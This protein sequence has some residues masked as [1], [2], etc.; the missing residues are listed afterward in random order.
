[1]GE[2]CKEIPAVKRR[3]YVALTRQ[4]TTGQ[5]SHW[6]FFSFFIIIT[7]NHRGAR[8]LKRHT[9]HLLISI[10]IFLVRLVCR[11]FGFVL[12]TSG[13]S[14]EPASQSDRSA[15]A[16]TTT[17]ATTTAAPRRSLPVF[18]GNRPGGRPVVVFAAAARQQQSR[19]ALVHLIIAVE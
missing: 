13:G 8:E 4:K 3:V 18:D 14:F 11:C 7:P 1:M 17:T 6:F 5:L 16:A 2:F 19:T 9:A 15:A 10:V 12:P